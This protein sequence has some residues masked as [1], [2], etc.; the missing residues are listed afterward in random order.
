MTHHLWAPP[1]PPRHRAAVVTPR[2]ADVLTGV[3]LGLSNGDIG[4]RLYLSEDTVKTHVKALR[5]HRDLPFPEL[6]SVHLM[7]RHQPPRDARFYPLPR[8]HG[9]DRGYHQHRTDGVPI[10]QPCREAHNE[11]M[12]KKAS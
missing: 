7:A 8:E 2:Q 12:R 9:T 10:C 5:P 6:V 1:P 4:A 11:K 3:V